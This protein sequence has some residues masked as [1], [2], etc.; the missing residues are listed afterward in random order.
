M[1][2]LRSVTRSAASLS[3]ARE[4]DPDRDRAR[5]GD[6]A[7]LGRRAC[8]SGRHARASAPRTPRR[9][10]QA[11][12]A[13]LPVHLLLAAAGPATPLAPGLRR[14]PRRRWTRLRLTAGVWRH[15]GCT[16]RCRRHVVVP[17]CATSTARGPPRPAHRDRLT[18]R[19]HR[20]L[21]AARVGD[22]LPAR[23]RR[24]PACRLAVAPRLRG[25]RHGRRVAPDRLLALRR[26]PLLHRAGT[27]SQ[28]PLPRPRRPRRLRAAGVPARRD[29]PLQA[30]VPTH[31]AD[32]LRPGRRLLRARARHPVARHARGA[33]RP[34]R[35]GRR[36][37]AD[38][39]ARRQA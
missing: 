18:P 14:H 20:L 17:R 22:G 3:L 37:G 24:D 39:D 27:P 21:R 26:L 6:V 13:R 38:R 31:P 30:R 1:G 29:G 11:P 35:P 28:H 16:W 9:T 23:R 19:T 33:V 25:H 12:R 32:P 36:A 4:P 7:R 2:I 15:G 34:E 10:A 8:R 5:R